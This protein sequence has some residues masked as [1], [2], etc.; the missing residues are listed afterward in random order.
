MINSFN[1]NGADSR[2]FGVLVKG[3]N[4]Y[5]QPERDVSYVSIPGRNGD[6]VFDNGRFKNINI[7]YPCRL[8]APDSPDSDD[9]I[10]M[11][12]TIRE[13]K[14]ALRADGNYYILTDTF[15][16]DYF[17]M[18]T[19]TGGI[20]FSDVS[21]KADVIDFNVNFYC[22]PQLYRWDGQS[23][24]TFTNSGSVINASIYNPEDQPAKPIIRINVTHTATTK[25]IIG[26]YP[27]VITDL[28]GYI[29]ID[30]ET[31]NAY[32]GLANLNNSVSGDFPVLYP[33]TN[34]VVATSS[35][36]TSIEIT[37]RWWTV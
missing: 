36:V 7:S 18:A 32:K 37:P 11:A 28:P 21:K 4:V 34:Q 10:S 3:R 9:N 16:P 14:R 12:Y 33:G 30:C 6:L 25:V 17:R 5:N 31:M 27:I 35:N 24:Q 22:K 8:F 23:A 29:D 20:T 19:Y 13:L 15:N 2:S 26:S 1:F